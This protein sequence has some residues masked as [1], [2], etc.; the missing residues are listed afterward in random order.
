M[1]NC[2]KLKRGQKDL[3]IEKNEHLYSLV[4]YMETLNDMNI[5]GHD[6]VT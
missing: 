2:L 5:K 6:S 4:Y 1:T 3:E